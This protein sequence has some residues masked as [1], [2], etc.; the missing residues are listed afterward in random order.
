MNTK[1]K[2]FQR[3]RDNHEKN[4]IYLDSIVISN[5]NRSA[6]IK[7]KPFTIIPRHVLQV[8]RIEILRQVLL[9]RTIS[10]KIKAKRIEEDKHRS[11]EIFVTINQGS[12]F[13]RLN[14]NLSND[15]NYRC[16]RID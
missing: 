7:F 15:D 14:M 5:R 10:K 3:N 13:V 1:V 16:V 8:C 11:M 12:D 6:Q 2:R 4:R 9:K